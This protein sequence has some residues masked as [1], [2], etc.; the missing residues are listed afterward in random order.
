[1]ARRFTA[2]VGVDYSG[3]ATAHDRLPGLAVYR[4]AAGRDPE[5][6]RP[7]K[8][9]NWTRA[10]LHQWLAGQLAAEPTIAGLDFAFAFPEAYFRRHG[11]TDWDAFLTDFREHWPTDAHGVT[12]DACRP[13]N[14]RNG[15]PAE[16][17]LCECWTPAAKSV[18]RFDVQGAVAKSTHAGL[19]W[20]ARLRG[21]LAGQVH[22]WPFDGFGPAPGKSLVAEVYPALFKRRFP[23][24]GRNDHQQDAYAVA[25]WLAET[26][27]RGL[28][29]RYLQPPLTPDETET[30][31][32][33]GWI[34]GVN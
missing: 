29:D 13:A 30:A 19:P 15:S 14:P 26:D 22:F 6:V 32:R 2:Y 23:A 18:F 7:A 11:L 16:L 3:A 21:E 25:R 24:E 28:L 34:L 9:G 10:E 4:A 5:R 8:G 17:R 20:L 31:H 12:V 27:G 33:E 1:V